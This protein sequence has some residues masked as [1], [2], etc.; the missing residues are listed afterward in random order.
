[1]GIAGMI[2][3]AN[4]IL[5]QAAITLAWNGTISYTNSDDWYALELPPDKVVSF[6]VRIWVA[7]FWLRVG[8]QNLYFALVGESTGLNW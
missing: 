1:M 4:K 7:G 8:V 2:A 3:D 6:V 5:W